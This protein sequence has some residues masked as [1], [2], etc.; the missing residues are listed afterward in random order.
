[1]FI[2][3]ASLASRILWLG[4]GSSKSLLQKC[5]N[6]DRKM[7]CSND[8]AVKYSDA[9]TVASTNG[10]VHFYVIQKY[11][12]RGQLWKDTE[13]FFENK[14]MIME[15]HYCFYLSALFIITRFSLNTK[16]WV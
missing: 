12:D 10:I 6:Y 3:K 5:L 9:I 16:F 7:V 14:V 2:E 15:I 13:P 8:S 4:Y 1:M 11:A